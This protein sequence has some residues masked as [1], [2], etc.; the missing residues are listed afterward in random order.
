MDSKLCTK[1]RESL[2]INSFS[3]FI[4]SR[5]GYK[6]WCKSC[7]KSYM[8]EY[9]NNHPE[10]Q[11]KERIYQMTKN[12]NE[13][14]LLNNVRLAIKKCQLANVETPQSIYNYN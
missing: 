13:D 4:R 8:Q 3:K 7:S 5:D 10:Y 9:R 14:A 6:A 12:N 2:P 1:C 11:Q